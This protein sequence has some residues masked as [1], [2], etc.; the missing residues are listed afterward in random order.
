MSELLPCVVTNG[1]PLIALPRELVEVWR[2]I[3]PPLG[4][5]VPPGWEWGDASIVCDYDRACVPPSSSFGIE[6][7]YEAWPVSVGEGVALVLDEECSTTA[8]R[9]EEGL[10]LVRD[11]GLASEADLIR[12]VGA[13]QE[14]SW[15]DT[16]FD[17]RVAGGAIVV[18]D[19]AFAGVESDLVDGGVMEAEL[20]PGCYRIL[21]AYPVESRRTTLLRLVGPRQ[22]RT[23]RA[24]ITVR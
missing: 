18:F 20:V 24:G 21:L 3:L 23:G 6:D 17:L 8:L 19:A 9:W 16:E 5:D 15:V 4:A 7:S 11:P 12:D 2:G 14:G 22:L 13:V 1:G 10:V